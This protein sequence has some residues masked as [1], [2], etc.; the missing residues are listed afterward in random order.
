MQLPRRRFLQLTAGAATLP[1]MSRSASAQAYPTRPIT[2]VVAYAAGGTTDIIS[3]VLAERMR[4]TLGQAVVVENV[5]GAGGTLGAARAARAAPDGY[6]IC[7]SQNGT[8]VVAGATYPK[9]PYDPVADF[10]P[11]S[12]VSISPFVISAKKAVPAND[13]KGLLEWLKANP[14]RTFATTGHGTITHIFGL[15]LENITGIRFQY[16]PY[17]GTAPAM[18]DLLA[19]QIDILMSDPGL[20]VPQGRNG[21][22]KIFAVADGKRLSFAPEIATVEEGGLPGYHVALWHG[23][24]LPKGT[25]RADHGKAQRRRG[26]R[27][28]RPGR[29]QQ[30][31]RARPGDLSARPA[32]ARGACGSAKGRDREMVSDHQGGRHQAG[33]V[34]TGA[35]PA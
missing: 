13:F 12:L 31:H 15:M 7:V 1:A 20:A 25:P 14:G 23:I 5:T 16:V 30:A 22:V 11:L 4:M 35:T 26:R 32:D 28:G 9:L 34:F 29:A 27:L 19:G 21:S 2:I 18:Q 24:W 17:R 33:I 3:R 10:E 8:H 6:T